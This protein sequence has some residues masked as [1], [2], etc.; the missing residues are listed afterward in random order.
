MIIL[1]GR[2]IYLVLNALE[3]Q[4]TAIRHWKVSADLT[5]GL[6]TA[7]RQIMFAST[8]RPRFDAWRVERNL[9]SP[10]KWSPSICA[11]AHAAMYCGSAQYH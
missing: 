2:S 1:W 4:A 6:D 7:R 11:V 9:I 10:F 3:V 5:I 8:H